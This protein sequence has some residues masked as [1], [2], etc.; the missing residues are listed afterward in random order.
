MTK[1]IRKLCTRKRL[2]NKQFKRSGSHITE[3]QFKECSSN[4]KKAIWKSHNNYVLGI[5][6]IAGT[7]PKKNGIML[8]LVLR[9]LPSFLLLLIMV[10]W[11]TPL[12]LLKIVISQTILGHLLSLI[13]TVFLTLPLLMVVLVSDIIFSVNEVVDILNELDNKKISCPDGIL[14]VFLRTCANELDPVLCNFFNVFV[15]VKFHLHGSVPM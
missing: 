15:R 10:I 5:S 6:K 4:L 9:N 11:L 12:I 14:P 13:C 2:L 8:D 1:E 7:N 3:Q